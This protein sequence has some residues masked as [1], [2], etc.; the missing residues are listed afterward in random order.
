MLQLRSHIPLTKVLAEKIG[1]YADR[2]VE[3]I[4]KVKLKQG[5]KIVMSISGV[6]NATEM[7]KLLQGNPLLLST[8]YDIKRFSDILQISECIGSENYDQ[9]EDYEDYVEAR[10]DV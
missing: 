4:E 2:Y 8:Y 5:L 6:S 1:N 7:H 3:A 9:A 10:D